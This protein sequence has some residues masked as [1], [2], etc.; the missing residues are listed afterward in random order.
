MG[1][2]ARTNRL[3]EPIILGSA[4]WSLSDTDDIAFFP[5]SKKIA[6][7]S[8]SGAVRVFSPE[9]DVIARRGGERSSAESKKALTT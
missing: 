7:V 9:G 5:D 3:L 8:K 1:M 6:A 2:K 4:R